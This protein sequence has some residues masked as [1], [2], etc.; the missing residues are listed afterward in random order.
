MTEPEETTIGFLSDLHVLEIADELGEYC[1]KVLAGLGAHVTKVEPPTGERTRQY[2]PFYEDIPG[3]DRSLYFWHYNHGKRGITLDLDARRGQEQFRRLVRQADVLLET[4]PRGYLDERHLSYD[5]LRSLHPGL[6]LARISPFG[7]TGPWA[8]YKGSD[9]VHL[10]L[11]G[12]MMNCGYDPD[13][14]G[15]YDTPPIAPQMWQ[16]YH[17]AGDLAALGILGA[18]YHR[19]S[20]GEGQRLST[21]V[22]QAVAQQTETDMPDWVYTRTP[23]HRLTCR[24][25]FADAPPPWI[26]L[27]K[28]GRWMLPYRPYLTSAPVDEEFERTLAFLDSFRMAEELKRDD[29]ASSTQRPQRVRSLQFVAAVDRLISKFL[30]SREIWRDAQA[31]G[32]IWAPLRKPEENV[33]DSHWQQRQTFAQVAHPELHRS[34]TYVNAR[35]I[36]PQVPWEAGV[37]APLLGEHNQELLNDSG[38][39]PI[40][41]SVTITATPEPVMSKHGKP[42]AM[43]GI[44]I[45]DLSW[46]LASAGAGRFLAA[47]GAEVIK[48]EHLSRLDPARLVN[49]LVHRGGREERDRAS[50]P[51]R[52]STADG[53][54]RSGFFMEINAGKRAISLNLKHPRG[55][56]LLCELVKRADVVAEGFSPGTMERMDLGYERLQELNPSIVYVQQSGMGQVGNYGRMRSFGPVAQGMSGLSEMS[57]LPEPFPPAGIGYSYLDWCGAY[58]MACAIMAA[59]YRRRMTGKGCWIDSSQVEAGLYLTGTAI[60]DFDANGRTW[61][62]Y[63]NASPYKRA[64]PHGAYRTLGDD[65]WIAIACFTQPEWEQLLDVLGGPGWGSDPRFATLDLRLSHHVEL[66][67]LLNQATAKRPPFEL[68]DRL[69]RAGVAAGV[70]QTA[71]DRYETDPQLKHL[72]WMTELTQSEIGTWPVK[73]FPVKF[74][75]TPAYMGGIVGRHGPSYGEDNGYVLRELLG[76]SDREIEELQEESVI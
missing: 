3:L 38:G 31:A 74:S 28:D 5:E 27:T 52:G 59:L 53:P 18:L 32:L 20:T 17:I 37:R 75:S 73:E 4:R 45:V 56:E 72:E 8:D 39:E 13:P 48:V 55:K 50:Q 1:G 24:H 69:Q 76:L 33:A 43:A 30:F 6:I 49:S 47:L 21:A 36:S 44:R 9:L 40:H 46:I 62:R 29:P 70:C 65:R 14:S 26:S 15:N 63:G 2:G 19:C 57:G 68:M 60:L 23:H 10:A 54:N 67:S 64:A 34:F 22:H 35:W 58:N 66:D 16:A 42:F 7:D 41:R 11:G 61:Q 25:S 12:V 71:E 51:L